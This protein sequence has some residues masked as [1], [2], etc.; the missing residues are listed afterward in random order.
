MEP[1]LSL[2]LCLHSHLALSCKPPP[3]VLKLRKLDRRKLQMSVTVI[4]QRFKNRSKGLGGEEGAEA[5]WRGAREKKEDRKVEEIET[6]V[7][8]K[9]SYLSEVQGDVHLVELGA[10]GQRRAL[11]P[12]LC[13]IHGVGDGLLSRHAGAA[14]QEQRPQ[15]QR[16]PR[17]RRR[18]RSTRHHLHLFARSGT[19]SNSICGALPPPPSLPPVWPVPD[20]P[21]QTFVLLA[22]DLVYFE[23][24]WHPKE[25]KETQRDEVQISLKLSIF[26]ILIS[27]SISAN[28]LIILLQRCHVLS[29]L[30]ELPLLHPLP[31]IPVDEGPLGFA[32][33]VQH[34]LDDLFADG[35]VP[36]GVVVG[37]IL[38]AS[39]Q[40]LRV[41]QL[42]VHKDGSWDVLPSSGL[43]E[44]SVEG[45]IFYSRGLATGHQSVRLDAVFQAVKLPAGIANLDASLTDVHRDTLTLE[46]KRGIDNI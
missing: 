9:E 42:A 25:D 4:T 21:M 20:H 10:A 19:Y 38:L 13:P 23:V 7:D 12:A 39:D 30:G 22:V 27:R 44:E 34:Q 6:H 35:V 36:A 16:D 5:N 41:E 1:T 32:G 15:Q 33:P 45:I 43:T 3:T 28:L 11:P 8:V 31:H 17:S 37:S 46:G 24:C 26:F 18:R 2:Q 40:L 14:G 29:G